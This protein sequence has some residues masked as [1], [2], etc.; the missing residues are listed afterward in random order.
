MMMPAMAA[1][2]VTRRMRRVMALS[3]CYDRKRSRTSRRTTR[4]K[5]PSG[6]PLRSAGQRA[7]GLRVAEEQE[8]LFLDLG[9]LRARD[10]LG[11]EPMVG[12]E[13]ADRV[14]IVRVAGQEIGLA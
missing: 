11:Y 6:E 2:R 9:P 13:V 10:G 3:P 4:P 12:R 7:G 1:N 14:R 5:R 8:R